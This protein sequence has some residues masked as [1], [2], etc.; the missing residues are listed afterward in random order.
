MPRADITLTS[1]S[2]ERPP[3]ITPTR[4]LPALMTAAP[5][6]SAAHRTRK[7]PVPA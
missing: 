4:S 7:R 6:A 5:P 1:C 3:K 2:P